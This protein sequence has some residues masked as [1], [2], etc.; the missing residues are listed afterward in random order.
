M[1]ELSKILIDIQDKLVP[2]LDSYEQAI[3]I[4]IYSAILILKG[5]GRWYSAQELQ[6]LDL[7]L[8]TKQSSQAGK[9]VLTDSVL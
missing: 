8:A 2:I 7:A 1:A 9:L 6:K 4:I 5:S 3:Y